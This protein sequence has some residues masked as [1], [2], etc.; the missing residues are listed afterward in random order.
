M[1]NT[2]ILTLP[3]GT[4]IGRT[5]WREVVRPAGGDGTPIV[6]RLLTYSVV[7]P[8]VESQPGQPRWV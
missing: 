4:S 8:D 2:A 6:V 7:T 5:L 3:S 1:E